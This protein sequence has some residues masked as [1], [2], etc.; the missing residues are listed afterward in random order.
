MT[1]DE[2][3]QLKP[4]DRVLVEMEVSAN[5]DGQP[6][7]RDG[8]VFLYTRLVSP[9]QIREKLPPP[10]RKFKKGDIVAVKSGA[11][12]YIAK[13]EQEG[14]KVFLAAVDGKTWD[15]LL[16]ASNLKLICAAEDRADRS[17]A[18]DGSGVTREGGEA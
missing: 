11:V 3:R 12:F 18:A 10:R 5:T 7:V 15:L 14:M 1:L 13:D 4:G 16:D 9:E 2:A 17:A 6:V 8:L